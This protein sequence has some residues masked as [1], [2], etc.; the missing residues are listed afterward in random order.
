M[1]RSGVTVCVVC[2]FPCPHI[3]GNDAALVTDLH[4]YVPDHMENTVSAHI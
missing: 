4:A 3:F 2:A 1:Q